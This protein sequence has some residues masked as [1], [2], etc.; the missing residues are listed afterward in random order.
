M[1]VAVA[2]ARHHQT[3]AAVVYHLCLAC[4]DVGF[5]SLLVTHVNVFTVFHGQRLCHLIVLCG[6]NLAIDHKIG[7]VVYGVAVV[8]V[9]LA[10]GQHAR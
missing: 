1:G 8:F 5:G 4:Q 3:F 6:E 10:A 2:A 7:I 9:V